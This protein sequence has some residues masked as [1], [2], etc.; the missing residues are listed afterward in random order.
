MT[1]RWQQIYSHDGFGCGDVYRAKV[2][3]GWLVKSFEVNADNTETTSESMIFV[4][5]PE[6]KWKIT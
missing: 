3:G 5:D 6:Y 1:F 2:F 4:P